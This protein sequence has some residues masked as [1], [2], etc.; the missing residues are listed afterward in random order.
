MWNFFEQP[1]TLL[2]ASILTLLVSVVN[3]M[4]SPLK[5][6]Q[7]LKAGI[8]AAIFLAISA[9]A[10]DALVDTDKE[11]INAVIEK[12]VDAVENEDCKTI[13]ELIAQNYRDS[14]Q[15]TKKSLMHDCIVRLS[16]PLVE[17]NVTTI[18]SLEI[19]P[20]Q[21]TTI[22]T[23]RMLFDKESFVYQNFNRQMFVK[24]KANLRKQ[25]NKEWLIGRVEFF[26]INRQPASWKTIK[27]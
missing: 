16:E 26:E 2:F 3:W 13:N 7:Y 10:F 17:K 15:R 23:V 12:A 27:N 24:V 1:F 4:I 22:F 8:G 19:A 25:P 20:P 6:S 11:K 14:Y 9:F 18:L 5:Q 21:A